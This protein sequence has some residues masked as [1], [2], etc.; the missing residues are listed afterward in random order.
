[1]KQNFKKGHGQ[2]IVVLVN[3]N[4]RKMHYLCQVSEDSFRGMSLM[5]PWVATPF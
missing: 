2:Y 5:Y 4:T 1:M 3:L